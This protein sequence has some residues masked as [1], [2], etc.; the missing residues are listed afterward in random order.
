MCLLSFLDYVFGGGSFI[1]VGSIV[2]T[3]NI[4][5][6]G[7]G[8]LGITYTLMGGFIILEGGRGGLF[9]NFRLDGRF[10]GYLYFS[11][12]GLGL[13]CGGRFELYG[14]Y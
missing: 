12:F 3:G 5:N 1:T 14:L 4:C 2:C 11:Y 10:N 8:T 7:L 9:T 6:G 13:I